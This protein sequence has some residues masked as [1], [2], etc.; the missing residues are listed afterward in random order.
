[1]IPGRTLILMATVAVVAFA[2]SAWFDLFVVV[3]VTL[4]CLMIAVAV[5]DLAT[6]PSPRLIGIEREVPDVLGVGVDN[7]VLLRAINRSNLPVSLE[8]A[9]S[10]PQPCGLQH[11]PVTLALPPWREREAVY[12]ITP[13]ERGRGT[14]NGVYLRY[15]SRFGLWV[16]TEYRELPK[17]VRIYPDI[18]AVAR[19]ELLATKNR[20]A[21]VGVNF[22]RLRGFGGEFERLREYR[23]EDEMRFIDWKATAKMRRLISREYNVERNQNVVILLDCGRSMRN[24]TGGVSHLDLALNAATIL[25]HVA[26]RQGDY[27]SLLAFS[28][29]THRY[30]GPLRGRSAMQALV[31]QIFDLAPQWEIS[32]YGHACDELLRFQRKRALVILVTHT[33]DEQHLKTIGEYLPRITGVHLMLC[34]FLRHTDL[35]TLATS[36]PED[37]IEAFEVAG[38]AELMSRQAHAL[39]E[40][41]TSGA[42]MLE[43]LPS[44]L[45]PALINRYL[46]IKARHLL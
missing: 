21:D 8:L 17:A 13:Y 40:L 4:N 32:D 39:A 7:P 19:F 33:M 31:P 38:A 6:T 41:R 11:H 14:F 23:R 16:R 42:L 37:E 24:E 15:P 30:V 22:W 12:R 36:T 35:A 43:V 9:D 45:S 29:R 25:S 44:E 20:L 46:D 5:I 34:V 26:L 27:V 28:D 18:R 10:P 2:V 3:G 1:M